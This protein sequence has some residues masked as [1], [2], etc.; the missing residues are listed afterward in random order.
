MYTIL[1]VL[2]SLSQMLY[3]AQ[4]S[5]YGCSSNAEVIE[6]QQ[7]R[8]DPEAFQKLLFTQVVYG[9]CITIGQGAVVEGV[10]DP[11]DTTVLRI[12]VQSDPPGYIVPW[13]DFKPLEADPGH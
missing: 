2:I 6:L 4:V 10:A 9:Q 12:N 11:T 3:Q 8:A 7:I 13:G 1:A 5:S